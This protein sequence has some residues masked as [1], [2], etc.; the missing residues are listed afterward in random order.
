[1]T[2]WGGG[3]NMIPHRSRFRP[4][5]HGDLLGKYYVDSINGTRKSYLASHFGPIWDPAILCQAPP[6]VNHI[7]NDVTSGTN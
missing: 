3:Y 5:P 1:M 7:K 4:D 6:N 2:G